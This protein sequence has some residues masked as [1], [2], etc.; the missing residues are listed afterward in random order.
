LSSPVKFQIT[1]FLRVNRDDSE[2]LYLQLVNQTIQA[3]QRG[4]LPIGMKLP[5]TRVLS[6]ELGVHR[7]TVVAAF[8]EL[9]A[10]GWVDSIPNSGTYIQNPQI[11]RVNSDM[12]RTE[13]NTSKKHAGFPFR[14][15]QLLDFHSVKASFSFSF[16][17]N[18]VDFHAV[19]QEELLRF[20]RTAQTRK[21]VASWMKTNVLVANP[22]LLSQLSFHINLTRSMHIASDNLLSLSSREA[23]LH[24]IAQCLFERSDVL[25]VV[26]TGFPTANYIFQSRD[27]QLA[28]VPIDSEGIDVNAI[29]N[30]CCAGKVRAVYVNSHGHYPTTVAMSDKRRLELLELAAEFDFLVIED[31][32]DFDLHYEKS[33]SSPMIHHDHF[34]RVL[35]VG[36]IGT[37]LSPTF[38][39]SFIVASVDVINEL[40]KYSRLLMTTNDLV[41][42]QLIGELIEE[43]LYFRWM[44]KIVKLYKERR[45]QLAT[46]MVQ[47]FTDDVDFQSPAGGTAIWVKWNKQFS[48]MQLHEACLAKD[49]LLPVENL[50]QQAN[51][52]ATRL[53]F[54]HLTSK[55]IEKVVVVLKQAYDEV[56]QQ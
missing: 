18:L 31:D 50:H 33:I 24:T 17:D 42:E 36:A 23:A 8:E 4:Y 41:V 45:N 11:K 29:R 3:I 1:R 26:G 20:Y 51:Y 13:V 5:G 46:L 6:E 32:P 12:K 30:T 19:K 28:S 55:E 37:H 7:K 35:Y 10:Q 9:S 38:Q 15:S 44:K 49:V 54:C 48:L 14:K 21:Q 52:A 56:M 16:S 43:G 40:T 22:Y 25:I 2:A 47:H 34:G 53:G 27:V 39:R